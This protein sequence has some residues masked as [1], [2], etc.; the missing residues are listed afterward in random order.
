M[1][2]HFVIAAVATAALVGI[3]LTVEARTCQTTCN[4][5]GGQTNCTQNCW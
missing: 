1:L 4:T 2:K 5:Y 3:A